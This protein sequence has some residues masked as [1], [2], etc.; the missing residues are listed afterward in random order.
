MDHAARVLAHRVT[1]RITDQAVALGAAPDTYVPR[2]TEWHR[3]L[4]E[5]L[6]RW[7]LAR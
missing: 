1:Y 6:R 3:E 2:R 5:G 7:Q 4:V